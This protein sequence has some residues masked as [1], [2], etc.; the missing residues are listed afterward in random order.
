M[1]H[2]SSILRASPGR[3]QIK[4]I[5]CPC[6][7]KRAKC[8]LGSTGGW[9]MSGPASSLARAAGSGLG[10]FWSF[11]S[12]AQPLRW[13]EIRRRRSARP[14]PGL[15]RTGQALPSHRPHLHPPLQGVPGRA[16]SGS[17]VSLLPCSNAP[18]L[19]FPPVNTDT[20]TAVVNVTYA[21]KEEAKV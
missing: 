5:S 4:K 15:S 10:T 12:P 2:R 6:K 16:G 14:A 20:E 9:V 7:E 3:G 1:G 21:T 13:G 19:A 8:C 18:S 17:D 11:G